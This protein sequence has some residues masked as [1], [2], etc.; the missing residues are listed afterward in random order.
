[1][2]IVTIT[3]KDLGGK[4][5]E[6][7]VESN[8]PMKPGFKHDPSQ[9]AAQN[10]AKFCLHMMEQEK[11]LR[12]KDGAGEIFDLID[13]PV[14]TTKI[15]E[16]VITLSD[17]DKHGGPFQATFESA[18][19]LFL[20]EP[21][22]NCFLGHNMFLSAPSFAQWQGQMIMNLLGTV[23]SLGGTNDSDTLMRDLLQQLTRMRTGNPNAETPMPQ[24]A[25]RDLAQTLAEIM[26]KAQSKPKTNPPLYGQNPSMN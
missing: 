24:T 10:A 18:P 26:A 16:V 22:V 21:L 15:A 19:P 13:H 23:W 7:D 4:R 1:M 2:A 12:E 8:I 9:T 11:T 5:I 6:T 3:L 25:A 14:D 20:E 17:N